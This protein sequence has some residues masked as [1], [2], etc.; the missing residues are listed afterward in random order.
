M[1]PVSYK[2]TV[3]LEKGLVDGFRELYPQRGALKIFVN[4]CLRKFAE[5]HDHDLDGEI[6]KTVEF[7]LE[8]MGDT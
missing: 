6:T 2:T 4:S 5:I 3:E 1:M 8:E 7:A